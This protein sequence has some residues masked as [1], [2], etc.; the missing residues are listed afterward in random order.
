MN[1]AGGNSAAGGFGVGEEN[2]APDR[3]AIDPQRPETPALM[4]IEVTISASNRVGKVDDAFPAFATP[5]RC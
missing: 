4:A 2:G 3:S 1:S 5:A